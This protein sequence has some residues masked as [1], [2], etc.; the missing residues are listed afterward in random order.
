MR[1]RRT[2][3]HFVSGDQDV[4]RSIVLLGK[5][6][7]KTLV[8]GHVDFF[9]A[10]GAFSPSTLVGI[11]WGRASSYFL[12]F[13]VQFVDVTTSG[14]LFDHFTD[15]AFFA[16]VS[17]CEMVNVTLRT[18][19][20]SMTETAEFLRFGIVSRTANLFGRHEVRAV[21]TFTRLAP[22]PSHG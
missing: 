12:V 18:V 5:S 17:S 13:V 16:I 19:E 14:T 15:G 4:S 10:I 1:S 21:L 2:P 3:V 22:I 11:L 7:N 20:F 8:S 9:L 6:L